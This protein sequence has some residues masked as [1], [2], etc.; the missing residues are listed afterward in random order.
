MPKPELPAYL[1]SKARQLRSRLNEH[2]RVIVT[3]KLDMKRV[4]IKYWRRD[5]A[6]SHSGDSRLLCA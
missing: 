2:F 3:I 1:A 5:E 6:G 4:A